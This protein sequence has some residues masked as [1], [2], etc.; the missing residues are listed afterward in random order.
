MDLGEKLGENDTFCQVGPDTAQKVWWHGR[1]LNTNL[2][3]TT[4]RLDWDKRESYPNPIVVAILVFPTRL[5]FVPIKSISCVEEIS[6]QKTAIP[7]YFS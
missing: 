1:L 3:Q 4:N 6:I 7:P 2:F 5:P